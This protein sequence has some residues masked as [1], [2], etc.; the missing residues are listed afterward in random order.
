MPRQPEHEHLNFASDSDNEAILRD[1]R[2][3]N[4]WLGGRSLIRRVRQ[5]ESILDVAAGSGWLARRC[6]GVTSVDISARNMSNAPGPKLVADALCLPFADNSFDAVTSCL[7]LHHLTD[8]EVHRFVGEC[9][10][11]ARKEVFFMDLE[12]GWLPQRFLRWTKWFFRW[13]PLCIQDGEASVRA[14]FTARELRRLIPHARVR[15]VRPWFRLM[16]SCE[17]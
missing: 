3:I 6:P 4:R 17:K 8:E 7:F 14:A 10:R 12:R 2:F 15:R 11:V 16:L 13:H 5:Y 1:M 9:R